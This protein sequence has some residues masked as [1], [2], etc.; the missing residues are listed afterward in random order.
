MQIIHF[1]LKER[2]T[3]NPKEIEKLDVSLDQM[4]STR[5]M[6][7][8][9]RKTNTRTESATTGVLSLSS[10]DDLASAPL[11]MVRKRGRGGGGVI[12]HACESVCSAY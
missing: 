7:R 3:H 1:K 6:C 9:K 5:K 10:R 4:N 12:T 8:F 11:T 2:S